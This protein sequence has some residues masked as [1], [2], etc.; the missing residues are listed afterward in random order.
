MLNIVIPMAGA[1]SRFVK[2]GYITPKPFIEVLGKPMIVRVLENLSY[3]DARYILIVRKDHIQKEKLLIDKLKQEFNVVFIPI[4][5][6]TEGAACTVLFARKYIN[7]ETPLLVANSDQIIDMKLSDYIDDCKNRSLDGSILTFI[8]K[9]RDIKWSYAKLDEN[10]IVE[11]VREKE[12]ISDF[13]TVGLY[14]YEK[15]KDYVNSAIDMIIENERVNDE[16]YTCPVYNYFIKHNAKIGI[17]NI[18]QYQM[19]GLGTP[20][21]L[22]SY[23]EHLNM[24]A[25]L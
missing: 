25:S 9:S 11:E 10:K 16:F 22:E 15:G 12:A 4:D 23:K 5:K 8:D 1:G 13:A 20:E 3:Q 21:D 14:Y 7:D 2:A 19:H 17:Y 24:N 6:L 18:E